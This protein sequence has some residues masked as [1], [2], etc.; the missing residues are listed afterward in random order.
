M[1]RT[2]W[3]YGGPSGLP[4]DPA[5]RP[6]F[7]IRSDGLIHTTQTSNQ[8]PFTLSLKI[9]INCQ[10]KARY[11]IMFSPFYKKA[12]IIIKRRTL[13][14]LPPL[15]CLIFSERRPGKACCLLCLLSNFAKQIPLFIF[16]NIS[17]F[18]KLSQL[19]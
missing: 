10:H 9:F 16:F 5:R 14:A 2:V 8:T 17:T 19:L 1:A 7:S 3:S 13:G 6:S 4:S 11:S 15:L 18:Q 12:P